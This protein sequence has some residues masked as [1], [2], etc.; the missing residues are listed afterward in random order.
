MSRSVACLVVAAASLYSTAAFAV[1]R[2]YVASYG[3]DANTSTS[4]GPTTPCR[5]F[6]AAMSV[7][8]TGGEVIVLDSAGYGSVVIT[9]SISLIAPDGIYAGLTASS[10]A[11]VTIDGAGA[12]VVLRGLTIKATGLAIPNGIHMINGTS[13]VVDRCFLSGFHVGGQQATIQIQ[14]SSSKVSVV[15]SM[16]SDSYGGIWL[17]GAST[18]T[19]SGSQL[20]GLD[21]VG[22]WVNPSAGTAQASV[23]TTTIQAKYGLNAWSSSGSAIISATGTVLTGGTAGIYASTNSTVSIGNS[24]ISGN[25]NGIQVSSPVATVVAS[26]NVISAN[27]YGIINVGGGSAVVL[28]NNALYGNTTANTSGTITSATLQ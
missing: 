1:P 21:E 22:I 13:L 28:G 18:L 17:R 14:S 7:A 3:N 16:I 6:T 11:V 15:N 8:D 4:C 10:G 2:A 26:G 19:V 24:L 12:I 9:K 5:T 27:S 20:V 25:T 23:D